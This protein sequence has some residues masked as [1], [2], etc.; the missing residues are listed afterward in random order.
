VGKDGQ[1]VRERIILGIRRNEFFLEYQPQLMA[2]GSRMVAVEALL[3]WTRPDS[4]SSVT[5]IIRTAETNG[6]IREL[7]AFVL[8][9]AC[10]QA[11]A[12]PQIKVAVNVSAVQLRERDFARSVEAIIRETGLP[13]QRLELE[14]VESALIEDF[15]HAKRQIAELRSL[16]MTVA[17]DDFGTGYSSL[18]YLLELPLDKLKIDRSIVAGVDKVQSAAIV[19]AVVALARALG[20]KV[21]AEGV[22]T[23]QQ[24]RFLRACG[25]HYL[26]GFLFSRPM[27][28][29]AIT[30]ELQGFGCE[31]RSLARSAPFAR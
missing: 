21:T 19:Q 8:R 7:G 31:P 4:A 27:A 1:D 18:T 29:E 25:C 10:R 12:W 9:E 11:T 22:E 5:E 15:E 2:D 30:D 28:A 13:P 3:R 14:I 24:H 17:L 6:A 26:Q 20:L 23:E 16:G